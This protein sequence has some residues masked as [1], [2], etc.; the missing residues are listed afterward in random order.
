MC[1]AVRFGYTILYVGDVP[2]SLDF[3]E[4]ALGQRRRFLHESGAVRGAR[5]RRH[6]ARPRRPRARRR[7][8]AGGLRAGRAARRRA[9]LRGL[10]RDARRAARPSTAPSTEGA[11]AVSP[12]QTKP[13]GQDVAYVRDPDGNLVEIASPAVAAGRRRLSAQLDAC[14]VDL[15]EQRSGSPRARSSRRGSGRSPRADDPFRAM[16]SAITRAPS[17]PSP[18][19]RRRLR[20]ARG[21]AAGS[22]TAARLGSAAGSAPPRPARAPPRRRGLAASRAS[23]RTPSLTARSSSRSAFSAES[24]SRTV[25]REALERALD[26][27]RARRQPLGHLRARSSCASISR[28][29]R[30]AGPPRSARPPR[31]PRAPYRP[32]PPRAA[33]FSPS[34]RS[35]R[36]RTGATA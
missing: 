17:W 25:R 36:E 15:V 11:E 2:A 10:L 7:Q 31:A 9:G 34:P 28:R 35:P 27:V 14:G 32:R 8:P 16:F 1:R 30:R 5:H 24:S 13:W 4:R 26:L 23:R 3:Y 20:S 22:S 6:R 29:P 18:A 12:P 19:R 21:R 33:D